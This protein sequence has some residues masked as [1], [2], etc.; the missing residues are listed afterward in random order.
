MDD[1]FV[2]RELSVGLQVEYR[3]PLHGAV[4]LIVLPR[5]RRRSFFILHETAP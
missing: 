4:S 3:L 2:E 1:D 5:L